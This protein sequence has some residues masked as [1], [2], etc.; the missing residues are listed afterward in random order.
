MIVTVL[1][2]TY[3]YT[4]TEDNRHDVSF[5]SVQEKVGHPN[6][7][8]KGLA[9]ETTTDLASKVAI[10]NAVETAI[11]TNSEKLDATNCLGVPY[12]LF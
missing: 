5:T 8:V 11:E 10:I 9:C 12:I 4:P 2:R 7:S 3:G 1:A 6:K